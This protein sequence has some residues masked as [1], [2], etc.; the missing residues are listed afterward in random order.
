[1][2][3]NVIDKCLAGAKCRHT[4]GH[5]CELYLRPWA[6]WHKLGGCESATNREVIKVESAKVRVGQQKQKKGA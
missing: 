2:I 6:K 3:Y 4:D 5:T 1:M